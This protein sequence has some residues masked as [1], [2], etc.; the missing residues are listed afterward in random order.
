MNEGLEKH[1]KVQQIMHRELVKYGQKPGCR[2][3]CM[4]QNMHRGLL[5]ELERDIPKFS[6]YEIKE[7]DKALKNKC[8]MRETNHPI[9][10]C[11][12]FLLHVRSD[13]RACL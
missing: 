11:I 4:N 13:V 6:Q 2:C 8:N 1:A 12:F 7:G 5:R 3:K 9:T 10:H